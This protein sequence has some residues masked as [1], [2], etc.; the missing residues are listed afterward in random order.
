MKYIFPILFLGFLFVNCGG[1]IEIPMVD[2]VVQLAEDVANI[3]AYLATNNLTAETTA[4]GLRFVVE[5]KG[6]GDAIEFTSTV[7]VLLEGY[8]LDGTTFDQTPECSPVSLFLPDLIPGFVEG[9]QQFNTWG[10]GKL[11]L[12]SALAFGQNGNG[13]IPANTVIAFDIE[14]VEQREFDNTKIKTYITDNNLTKMDSTLSGMYYTISE[15]GTGEH[16]LASS[17]VTVS[18]KGYFADGSVFDQSEVPITF[19]LNGVIQGWQEALPL[20]KKDGTGTFL[21]PSDLAYGASGSGSIPSNTMII[22][23]I[24]LIDF[25]E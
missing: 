4:S 17:T 7:N 20:L 1:D 8:F 24:T 11:F 10:K 2:P 13:S 14:I 9:V 23:D 15:A 6:R 18:Y 25:T 12:P 19:G 5:D 3:D 16:P 22:F 21:I